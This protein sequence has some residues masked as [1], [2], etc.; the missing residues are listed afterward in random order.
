MKTI[1]MSLT[2]VGSLLMAGNVPAQTASSVS[3]PATMAEQLEPDR[4]RHP[5]TQP[6]AA[7]N[8]TASFCDSANCPPHGVSIERGRKRP[9]IDGIG[10]LIGVPEKVLLWDHRA[11]NHNVSE[12]TTQQV[13]QYLRYRQLGDVKLRVN[14]Y[15][16]IGEWDRLVDNRQV[17]AGWK[18]TFGTLR[19][20][21]YVFLPGRVFGGDD[22][23]PYTNTVS[24]YSDMPSLGLAEAAYAYD[25]KQRSYPGTYAAVQSLPIV[26]M[27]HETLAT[28]E[29]AHYVAMRGTPQQQQKL[30]HDLYA[31]YGMSLGGE[32]ARVLPDGSNVFRLVGAVA[33]HTTATVENKI[34]YR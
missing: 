34:D 25:V 2:F 1:A 15:D 30:R 12:Q 33:G 27:W 22:Y 19:H 23:N 14:Q 20:L 32:V 29:V 26:A 10:W 7:Q 6:I 28:D 24:L 5:E 9:I 31:R 8:Q 4:V 16:P 3:A 13:A 11:N 17:G 18:Y 21:R